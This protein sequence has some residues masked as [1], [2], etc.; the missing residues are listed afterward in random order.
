MLIQKILYPDNEICN[1][2]E[3]FFRGTS[4][5]SIHKNSLQLK[6]NE[7][8]F[9][10]T[11]FN[12]FPISKWKKY[13][14]LSN[15]E[16]HFV[17][18]CNCNVQVYH[19]TATI[20]KKAINELQRTRNA[21]FDEIS[22]KNKEFISTKKTEILATVEISNS[23]SKH[24]HI[25]NIP[26]LY[27]DGL[28]YV[29]ITTEANTE[30]SDAGWH[31]NISDEQINKIKFAIGICTYKRE[32]FL[33]ANVSKVMNNIL[34]NKNSCLNN[35]IEVYIADNGQTLPTDCFDSPFVHTYPNLNLGGSAGF[36]RTIIESMLNDNG[37]A[38]SHIILMD[39][40]IVL[41]TDVLE[42]SYQFLCFLKPEYNK[43]MLGGAMLLKDKRYLQ[44]E[45]GAFFDG[46]NQFQQQN[47]L[48][49]LRS[50]N[51][52]TANLINNKANYQ[53]WWYCCIPSTIISNNNLPL[54][55][56]IHSDDVEYGIR[57]S[58]HELIL[59]NGI[60]TWHPSFINK[61]SLWTYYY[62]IRN[63]LITSVIHGYNKKIIMLC[64]V[65][66]FIARTLFH[67]Y[68]HTNILNKAIT[69]FLRGSDFFINQDAL[70]LQNQLSLYKYKT[71]T[72][73][74]LHLNIQ[75]IE[76]YKNPH[77]PIITAL[78]QFFSYFFPAN[79]KLVVCDIND[80]EQFYVGRRIYAYNASNNVGFLL[81]RD[82]KKLLI[83][84][85]SFVA[86]F[87]SLCFKFNK[88]KRNFI[89]NQKKLTSLEFWTDY[90]NLKD[91]TVD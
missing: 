72:P 27:N 20:D 65:R 45:N 12:S 14:N 23:K 18:D 15:L 74:E 49:D 82:F 32:E 1:E 53:A 47:Y 40:D 63:Y 6:S 62:D 39:D 10:N 78:K 59:L 5:D 4:A 54:P 21:T 46:S 44:Y 30:I 57:N 7:T 43:S 70:S 48:F 22:E 76:F 84:S 56:F 79:N 33:K 88:I 67:Q 60:C 66:A 90:L 8:V 85:I 25:V 58:N 86:K 91:G 89:E 51:C 3:M 68:V 2:T 64:I 71:I 42:R 55:F 73:E 28:I 11:Y 37:K 29:S 38:F 52:I 31:T 77:E 69:D 17:A 13:T 19:E 36:T 83:L 16:F 41:S 50:E 35:K 24:H 80:L 61:N 75:E 9:L 34:N 26:E 87:I 81:E